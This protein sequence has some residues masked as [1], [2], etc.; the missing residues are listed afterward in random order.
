MAIQNTGTMIKRNSTKKLHD[1]TAGNPVKNII[2]MEI[3]F[4]LYITR[5]MRSFALSECDCK[6]RS[7]QIFSRYYEDRISHSAY[8]LPCGGSWEENIK[9]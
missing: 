5:I 8:Y 9:S 4:D 2:V 1:I 7:S 6:C 3:F